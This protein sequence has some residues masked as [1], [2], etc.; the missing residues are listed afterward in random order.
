M[1]ISC[2]EKT[3]SFVIKAYQNIFLFIHFKTDSERVFGMK[4]GN[5]ESL[6]RMKNADLPVKYGY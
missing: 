2:V 4:R 5:E 6:N 1:W 3:Y